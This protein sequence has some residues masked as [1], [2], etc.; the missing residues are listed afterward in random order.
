MAISYT[1]HFNFALLDTGSDGWDAETNS[2]FTNLDLELKA[3]QTPI[4]LTTTEVVVSRRLGE[5]ILK[6]YQ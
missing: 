1:T 4:I 5:I 3:A 2:I 6:H